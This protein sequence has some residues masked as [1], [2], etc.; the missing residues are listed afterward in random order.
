MRRVFHLRAL[1]FVP[2]FLLLPPQ[3]RTLRGDYDGSGH[4]GVQRA[5]ARYGRC[6]GGS[7]FR[8]GRGSRRLARTGGGTFPARADAPGIPSG[9]GDTFSKANVLWTY[10]SSCGSKDRFPRFDASSAHSLDPAEKARRISFRFV[11]FRRRRGAGHRSR[12]WMGPGRGD[13]FP[14]D[15]AREPQDFPFRRR[16]CV[17]R[18]CGIPGAAAVLVPRNGSEQT[19]SL[20][21]SRSGSR[22]CAALS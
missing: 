12:I 5:G 22:R 7:T 11:P 13:G 18:L 14:S 17:C 10:R 19:G 3:A 20:R 4:S 8:N 6:R 2:S 21:R 9:T 15:P 16:Q 1:R